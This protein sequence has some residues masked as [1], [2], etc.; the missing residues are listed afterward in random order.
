MRNGAT[1]QATL[2]LRREARYRELLAVRF[3]RMKLPQAA[4]EECKIAAWLDHCA[5]EHGTA[6]PS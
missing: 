4:E 3:D 1:E 2:T 5:K 6:T